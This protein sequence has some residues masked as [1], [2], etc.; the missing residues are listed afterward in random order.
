VTDPS[1]GRIAT[2]DSA[3][4]TLVLIRAGDRARAARVLLGLAA[5]QDGD[6]ALPFS[7][8]LPAPDPGA[9]YERAGAVA[10]AGYAAA[11]YLDAEEGGPARDEVL[12]FAHRAAAYLLARRVTAAGD[13][14]DGL[15]RGGRGTLRYVVEGDAVREL[16]EPG[17]VT[18]VSVEHNID[19]FFFLRALAR[20]TGTQAY[21]D[22]ADGI[23]QALVARAWDARR[24]Q[25]VQGIDRGGPD[26]QPALDCASWG[27]VFLEAV[28]EGERAERAF[29]TADG[30]YASRDAP[31]GAPGHRP[32]GAGP[33]LADPALARHFAGK[34]RPGEITDA[35]WDRLGIVWPEGSAGVA[36]AAWRTGR[37]R[38]ASAILDGL[39]ALRARDGAMPT[40]SVDVPFEFDRAPSLA[41]TAWV[42]LVRFELERPRDRPTLWAP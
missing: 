40:A 26:E 23:A 37:G 30:R 6:G 4:I 41:G 33:V 34:K 19:T 17:E 13:P 32:Y 2:Y 18:W 38:R 9:R 16:L 21:A 12:R 36:L 29:A 15:V 8:T 27:A 5:L 1:S 24:G 39:E 28:G 22:A 3:L 11:E 31:S 42:E 10:W 7:F 25:F 14:R 20:A 35:T